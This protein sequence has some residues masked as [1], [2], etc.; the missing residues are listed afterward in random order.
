MFVSKL[1]H[2]EIFGIKI[3]FHIR[4]SCHTCKVTHANMTL[5]NQ[6]EKNRMK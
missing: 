4:I 1:N 5:F 3:S 2:F 6:T